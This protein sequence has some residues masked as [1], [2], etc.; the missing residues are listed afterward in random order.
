MI[1]CAPQPRVRSLFDIAGFSTILPIAAT[2]EEAA[3]RIA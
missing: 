2:R 1:A 3:S